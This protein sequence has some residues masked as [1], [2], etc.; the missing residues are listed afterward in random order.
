MATGVLFRRGLSGIG[1]VDGLW[2]ANM[3]VYLIIGLHTAIVLAISA[4]EDAPLAHWLYVK[5]WS[6]LYLL[7]CPLL[8][9]SFGLLTIVHRTNAWS[10]RRRMVA[11][12][13]SRNRL[14]TYVSGL[15]LLAALMVFMG[16][17]TTFKNMMP[18][19]RDGFV[20]D[21]IQADID[22]A[23]HF[24]RDPWTY[25]HPIA[26]HSWL[27]QLIELNYNVIWFLACFVP[28]FWIAVSPKADRFRVR[29]FVCFTL[30]WIVLGN[31]LALFWLSAGPAFYHHVTGDAERFGGL[32]AFIAAGEDAPNSAARFQ[33]YLWS[34]YSLQRLG[35]G[36]GISAFPSVHVGLTMVNALFLAEYDR[37]LGLIAYL[38]VALIVMSSVYLGWHYAID[39]YVSIVVVAAIHMLAK[40]FLRSQEA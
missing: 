8:M 3:P 4:L 20:F 30:A 40:R 31:V 37:R 6:T 14:P 12:A 25:F 17:F 15:L 24:G 36:T 21:R 11:D 2:R 22:A 34:N 29:Y 26:A 1:N 9:I 16:S 39:G 28:I 18:L 19:M 13:F 32:I 5:Q 38:Y 23:L 33:D 7:L 27:R 10:L 35:F